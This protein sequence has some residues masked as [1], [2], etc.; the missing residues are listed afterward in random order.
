MAVK[1]G[2]ITY[3][4]NLSD[5]TPPKR[6]RRERPHF[7]DITR[8]VDKS[9]NTRHLEANFVDNTE[10][11]GI[12]TPYVSSVTICGTPG[13][14]VDKIDWKKSDPRV[15]MV[16]PS[17]DKNTPESLKQLRWEIYDIIGRYRGDYGKTIELI[18]LQGVEELFKKYTNS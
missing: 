16:G 12:E 6:E 11:I 13:N 1:Y 7:S 9:E 3:P 14:L 4:V 8:A 15:G 18:L 10:R 5:P 17:A 2:D